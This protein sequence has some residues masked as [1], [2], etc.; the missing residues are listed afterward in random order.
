MKT[1]SVMKTKLDIFKLHFTTPLHIGNNRADY[2]MSLRH[3]QSDTL[4]AAVTSC[5]AKAGMDIPVDGDLG[6]TI[7]SL[8]PYRGSTLF[9][10][11]PAGTKLPSDIAPEHIK[12]FKKVSWL[13]LPHFERAISGDNIY[14]DV[15]LDKYIDGEYLADNIKECRPEISSAVSPRAAVSRDPE[16]DT[17]PFYMDRLYFGEDSGFYFI[18]IGV[19]SYL[20]EGLALLKD[21][22]IGTDRNVGNGFFTYKK[23]SITLDTPDN[24]TGLM[25]LSVFIP[26][27][28]EQLRSMLEGDGVSYD[29]SRRGGWIT[30][31]PFNTYRKKAVHAFLPASVFSGHSE[32][33]HAEGE[34][35][36]LRP[37]IP[38]GPQNNI[39]RCGRSIFI[40]IITSK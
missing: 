31:P 30:T 17:E 8:F 5:L 7:S 4:Y 13:D 9:F 19:T 24:T 34:I 35:V 1:S 39:W 38:D 11:K 25:S 14:P 40:P 33:I 2:G 6:C 23:T 37:E 18:A 21:E 32:S 29:F 3:I 27:S 26:K 10:P 28:Q 16:K 20:E 36:N 22:G 15:D 12:L